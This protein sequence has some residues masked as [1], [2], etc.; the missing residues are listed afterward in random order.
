MII[1]VQYLGHIQ[2]IIKSK[3]EEEISIEEGSS[4]KDLLF[5]LSEKYG[6]L[7]EDAIY[8][9]GEADLK[10]NYMAAINCY[11]LNQLDGINTKLKNGDNLSLMPV[12]SGG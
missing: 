11:L 12:V 2:H 7:F 4:V 3:R 9:K 6:L 5:L 8:Q 1:K 10:S